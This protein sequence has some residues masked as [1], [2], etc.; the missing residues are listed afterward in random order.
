[1]EG[2]IDKAAFLSAYC[3][4]VQELPI[5]VSAGK[6]PFAKYCVRGINRYR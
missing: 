6:G 5:T 3:N 2:G 4:Y 1:M